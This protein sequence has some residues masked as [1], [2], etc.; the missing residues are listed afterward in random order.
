MYSVQSKLESLVD[1]RHQISS[2]QPKTTKEKQKTAQ[3]L[4]AN[5]KAIANLE[6]FQQFQVDDWV[7]DKKGVGQISELSFSPG[8]MPQVWVNWDGLPIPEQPTRLTVLEENWHQGFLKGQQVDF[9]GEIVTI[10]KFQWS[11]E[12]NCVLLSVQNQAKE[13]HLVFLSEVSSEG[14]RQ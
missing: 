7:T 10:I 11:T 2:K 1:Y 3:E 14:N 8:G 6:K 13:Q 9:N 12:N 4:E 5:Q